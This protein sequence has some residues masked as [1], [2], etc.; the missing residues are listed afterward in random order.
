MVN[1]S[2]EQSKWYIQILG[3]MVLNTEHSI[4]GDDANMSYMI[5]TFVSQ[6]I[7]F[8]VGKYHG[9]IWEPKPKQNANFEPREFGHECR[10][11]TLA[12]LKSLNILYT[13]A[14]CISLVQMGL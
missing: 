5:S 12:S 4:W 7:G 6:L 1:Q 8:K 3:L 2:E 14:Q 10:L 13:F 11:L 9:Y